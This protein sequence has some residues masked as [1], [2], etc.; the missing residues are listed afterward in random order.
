MK[1]EIYI[2]SLLSKYIA[3]QCSDSER[4]E[5]FVYLNTPT[6]KQLLEETMNAEAD[7]MFA[8]PAGLSPEISNR[9]FNR[10]QES[11]SESSTPIRKPFFSVLYSKKTWQLAAA[12]I[13]LLLI[14]GISYNR[15]FANQT[16]FVSTEAG[17]MRT[18]ILPDGSRV[19]LNSNSSITYQANW[20]GG[21]SRDVTLEG[22]A[23]F[24]VTHNTRQ[25]FFVKTPRM[26]I[27]VLGTAFNV[28]SRKEEKVFETTLV[29]GKVTIKDLES[30][31]SKETVLQPNEQAVFSKSSAKIE[32]AKIIPKE[33]SYWHKGH[34]IFE[35][36]PVQVITRELEK[37]YQV[38]I[39]VEEAS[40]NCRFNFN[41]DKE[42]LPEVL[43]LLEAVTG[44]QSVINGDNV[45]IKGKLCDVL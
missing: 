10:L 13:G 31:E 15:Y 9:I 34:L 11:I 39:E 29:R 38:K 36:E 45:V 25:P 12:F 22:E 19:V 35:D 24:D 16:Q 17:Q 8:A 23:F 42:T 27:K 6:G 18:V 2:R 44:A 28:K 14:F 33:N 26:E 32:T 21:N 20:S 40:K 3:N 1:N 4:E 37:W 7:Q 41:V 30:P 5:L 43:R